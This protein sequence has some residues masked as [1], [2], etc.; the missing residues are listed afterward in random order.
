M[1]ISWDKYFMEIAKLSTQR[2]K[3][4]KTQVGAVIVNPNDHH[5]ISVGYNGMPRGINDEFYFY[6]KQPFIP[7]TPVWND[8][9]KN[10]LVVH[11]EANAILNTNEDLHGAIM[12]VT[13]YPCNECA[14]L[15]VQ[16][17]IKKV[18]YA[19]DKFRRKEGVGEFS[20]FILAA[21]NI[22]TEY[23]CEEEE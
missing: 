12:Y 4:P 3:D 8:D 7:S 2:S 6:C 21:G 11:A 22:D 20:K 13:Q 1:A 19:D 17:G 23:Y 14:K 18:I 15:I 10:K 9:I 5:I 16:K